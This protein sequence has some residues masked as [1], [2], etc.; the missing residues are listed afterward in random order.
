[1]P[2]RFAPC[3]LLLIALSACAQTGQERTDTP[4]GSPA[5]AAIDPLYRHA[6]ESEAWRAFDAQLRALYAARRTMR[7]GYRLPV[8]APSTD[9]AIEIAAWDFARAAERNTLTYMVTQEV[10]NDLE[11][12]RQALQ[13]AEDAV[14]PARAANAE[15]METMTAAVRA[16]REMLEGKDREAN[17]R[18]LEAFAAKLPDHYQDL[19]MSLSESAETP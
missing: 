13:I 6:R 8:E 19:L 12:C 17:L 16:L 10:L 11:H 3:V 2:A 1:M 14:E 18:S 15:A 5:E 4:A 7:D 9:D